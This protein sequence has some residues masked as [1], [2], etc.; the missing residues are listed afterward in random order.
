[1]LDISVDCIKVLNTDGTVCHMNKSGCVALGVP[2]NE[3]NLE[4][5][6]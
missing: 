2:E 3:K 4:C 1:M 6:G 5:H